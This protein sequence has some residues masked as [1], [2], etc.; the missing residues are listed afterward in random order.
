MKT[1][2]NLWFAALLLML[3]SSGFAQKGSIS[4]KVTY[5]DKTSIPG[6][7]I[8]F[9]CQGNKLVYA[10]TD[11]GMYYASNLPAGTYD[12][13][14]GLSQSTTLVKKGVRIA[15][16]DDI[17]LNLV[18]DDAILMDS[19]VIDGGKSRKPLIGEVFSSGPSYDRKDVKDMAIVNIQQIPLPGVVQAENGKVYAHGSREGGV[20]YYIDNCKVMGSPNI[21]LCGLDFFQ[22]YIGYVPAKYGDSTGGV[23]AIETRNFFAE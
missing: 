9:V 13:S 4:G 14:V 15:S 6:A 19:I 17:T 18:Y 1:W 2:K 16:G 21:P 22:S 11:S 23:I 5:A 8:E 20:Q 7:R 3:C 12:I 10:T